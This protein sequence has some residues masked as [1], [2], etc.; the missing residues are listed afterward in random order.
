VLALL[1][2]DCCKPRTNHVAN[3]PQPSSVLVETYSA[4]QN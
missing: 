1:Y 2:A 3:F 4:F